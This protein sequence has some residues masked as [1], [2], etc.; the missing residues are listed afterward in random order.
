ME[1]IREVVQAFFQ[2]DS[3]WSIILRGGIWFAI[4]MVIIVSTDVARP[5][6]AGKSL[7]S[8]LGFFLLFT[9]L[10]GGLIYL[11]FGFQA[12]PVAG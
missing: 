1:Q 5:E 6:Q 7:K 8:N 4:A 12:T 2:V 3:I 10:T 11:L 9:I